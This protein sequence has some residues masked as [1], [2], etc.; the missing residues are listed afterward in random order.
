ML[1]DV[2]KD[3]AAISEAAP[4]ACEISFPVCHDESSTFAKSVSPSL[5]EGSSSPAK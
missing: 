1:L 5:P 4:E 3:F 2:A